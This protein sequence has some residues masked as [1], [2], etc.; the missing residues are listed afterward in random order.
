[1]NSTARSIVTLQNS[2]GYVNIQALPPE[3]KGMFWR[4]ENADELP[5]PNEK[6]LKAGEDRPLPVPAFSAIGLC[7]FELSRLRLAQKGR[8]LQ[9]QVNCTLGCDAFI[10]KKDLRFHL[11]YQCEMRHVECRFAP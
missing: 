10:L 8:L 5:L 1:M 7:P 4:W 2:P 6:E 3:M 11:M 9:K